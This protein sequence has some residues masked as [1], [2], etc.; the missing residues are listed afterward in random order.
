MFIMPERAEERDDSPL[1]QRYLDSIRGADKSPK[2]PDLKIVHTIDRTAKN[3]TEVLDDK[4]HKETDDF[5]S[6]LPQNN[7]A[8][9]FLKLMKIGSGGTHDVY[10][11]SKNPSFVVKVNR[12][13][14]QADANLFSRAQ[15]YIDN[16][17]QENHTLYRAFGAEN[18]A[19]ER[20]VVAKG[21]FPS[22]GGKVQDVV[23]IIQ[24][25]NEGLD[26]KEVVDFGFDHKQNW[27]SG[28][29]KRIKK[30]D[31]FRAK[32]V[33]F[34][35]K[36]KDY[37]NK[38]GNFID[39]IGEKNVV[40]YK[41]EKGEWQYKIGSVLKGDSREDFA[42]V[43]TEFIKDPKKFARSANKHDINTFNNG[44]AFAKG[45]NEMGMRLGIGTI[46][47][48]PVEGRGINTGD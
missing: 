7:G 48:I 32:V 36:F 47:Y 28:I 25:R 29:L 8:V 34:L 38:T 16:K 45:F 4:F 11:D 35:L 5:V 12:G 26:Q 9:D 19:K 6:H 10:R 30:D 27:R 24:E 13:H 41:D 22:S 1:E 31:A 14:L 23:L 3:V 43:Y 44:I 39:L 2:K 46:A 33:E 20:M 40:F 21:I 42:R 37:F 17:D 15:G 18:C